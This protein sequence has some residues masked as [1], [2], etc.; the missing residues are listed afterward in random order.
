MG[1]IGILI[2]LA[3]SSWRSYLLSQP[4][5]RKDG[6]T[7]IRRNERSGGREDLLRWYPYL[8]ILQFPVWK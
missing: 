6:R 3:V 8:Q 4:A 2:E 7:L 1:I 5:L